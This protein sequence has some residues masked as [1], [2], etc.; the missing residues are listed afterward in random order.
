MS[1]LESEANM[2]LKQSLSVK[3]EERKPFVKIALMKTLDLLTS[4]YDSN[5]KFSANHTPKGKKIGKSNEKS[6]PRPK[7]KRRKSGKN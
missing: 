4:S 5:G 6:S 1:E 2:K 3:N 7:N